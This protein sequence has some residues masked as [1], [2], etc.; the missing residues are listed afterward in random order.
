MKEP[1]TP[2]LD[3][4]R[5]DWPDLGVEEILDQERDAVLLSF[6]VEDAHWLGRHIVELAGAHA[7]DV[8]INIRHGRR[9]VF[10]EAGANTALDNESWVYRKS[11][12]VERLDMASLRANKEWNGDEEA[13]YAAKALTRPEYAI[14]GGAFPIR[15]EGVG[16]VGVATCSGLASEADHTLVLTGLLDL[17][18]RLSGAA[19][20]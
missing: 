4:D 11:N 9:R 10:M 13:F 12:V 1:I 17:K 7:A 20:D 8:T 14:H 18:A 3:L 6:S 2:D 5:T 15:V 19:G 16:L